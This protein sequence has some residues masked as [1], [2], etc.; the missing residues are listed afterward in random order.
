MLG[1]HPDYPFDILWEIVL[2]TVDARE[3]RQVV[4]RR[5]DDFLPFPLPAHDITEYLRHVLREHG[6]QGAEIAAIFAGDAEGD[7]EQSAV[8]EAL[9]AVADE[10][11][12]V[13]VG[14]ATP[15]HVVS[16][17]AALPITTLY[18]RAVVKIAFHYVLSHVPVLTGHESAFEPV[19]RFI[20]A[21]ENFHERAALTTEPIVDDFRW[22]VSLRT[23]GHFLAAEISYTEI[24]VRAQFFVGPA[25]SPPTWI[26][27]LARNPSR[28]YTGSFGHG[29]ILFDSPA[30]DG[31]QG[32]MVPLTSYSRSLLLR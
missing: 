17:S 25:V 32:E 3:L 28:V 6:L 30:S 15:G 9:R 22:G 5:G 1:K 20:S 8:M 21:G 14:K 29:F 2:G 24:R 10:G 26:I 13:K 4:V 16:V 27:R 23:Y 18:L 11:S 19:K 12:I 7:P 31:H